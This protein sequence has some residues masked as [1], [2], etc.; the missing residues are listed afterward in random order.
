MTDPHFSSLV[1]VSF[2]V[3]SPKNS[4]VA[5]KASI[6]SLLRSLYSGQISVLRSGESQL[7]KVERSGLTEVQVPVP[8]SNSSNSPGRQATREFMFALCDFVKPASRQWVIIAHSGSLALRNIDHLI[9]QDYGGPYGLPEVDFIW[10]RSG[11]DEISNQMASTG[12]WAVRGE[13][14][15]LVLGCL[16]E[17]WNRET[18]GSGLNEEEIWTRVVH[19]LPL[20]K[21][22]FEKGEVVAPRIGAVDWEAVGNAA[23][24]TVPDWPEKEAWKFLQ[25]LYFG[26]YLGDETGMML[27]ILEA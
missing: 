13:H 9:P 11:M 7:F 1:M 4:S 16:K 14:L 19:E 22:A 26:T 17:A 24:V 27:N 25:A 8:M 2:D 10:T 18:E 23:F 5:T 12:L 6:S 21:R 20:R 15:L 3:A